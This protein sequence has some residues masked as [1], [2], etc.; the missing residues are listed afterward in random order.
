MSPT[1]KPGS[2][3]S[4]DPFWSRFDACTN[5]NIALEVC[6]CEAGGQENEKRWHTDEVNVGAI[7]IQENSM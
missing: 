2:I 4:G 6:A 1:V 7:V 3:G 5:C